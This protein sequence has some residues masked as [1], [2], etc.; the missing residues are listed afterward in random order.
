MAPSEVTVFRKLLPK[1]D[2][3]FRHLESAADK[4]VEIVAAFR[5]LLDHLDDAE[6]HVQAVKDLEHAADEVLHRVLAELHQSFIT[7]LDRNEISTISKR[8]DDV[9]DLVEGAAQRM[10]HYELR[11]ATPPLRQLVDIL[12]QQVALVREAVNGLS[13]LRHPGRLREVLVEINT[14]ENAADDILR[15]T[16]GALFR[17][18]EDPRRI[19]KWKEVYE[20]VEKATD[21]CEDVADNIENILLEYA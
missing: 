11:E 20:H 14:L 5:A 19:L 8:L 18:E 7:P 2:I 15:P 6:R 10:Y 1:K 17:E 3:F 16:I 13:D 12:T 21:R 9:I 4:A